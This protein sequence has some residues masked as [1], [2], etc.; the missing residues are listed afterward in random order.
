MAM[1][2]HELATNAAKYGAL[3]TRDGRVSI[4]WDLQLNEQA[5]SPLVLEWQEMGGPLVVATGKPSYGTNTITDLIPYEF[6]GTVDL[7]MAPDGVRC[8]LA[9]PPGWLTNA[10]DV[11]RTL[12]H[13][14]ENPKANSPKQV[15]LEAGRT[16]ER[17]RAGPFA[18]RLRARAHEMRAFANKTVDTEAKH[19]LL[20]VADE[21]ECLAVVDPQG[22]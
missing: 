14:H 19:I 22:V 17:R 3:A 15:A 6:G 2:L 13:A 18:A 9:L 21:F 4:K 10:S 7:V 12:V 11:S 5:P 20:E 1:V 16:G 8:R